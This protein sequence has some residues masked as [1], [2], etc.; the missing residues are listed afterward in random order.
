MAQHQH[1][2]LRAALLALLHTLGKK[3]GKTKI[4]KLVYLTD[5][6][7]YRLRGETI[8]GLEY[9]RERGGPNDLGNRIVRMLDHLVKDGEL[10]EEASVQ[11]GGKATHRYQTSSDLDVSTLPLSGDDWIEI[12]T[13]VHKYGRMSVEDIVRES[14]NSIPVQNARE[15]ETLQLCQDQKLRITD[16]DIANDPLLLTA[17][18]ARAADT[19]DR[20]TLDD[21]RGHV[22]EPTKI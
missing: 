4:V 3:A 12:Q 11:P 2:R 8:T 5:E 20:I 1:A 14:R 15:C 22:G 19:G 6:A 17:V 7:N 21:L 9:I 13:A 10:T 16:E 18:Q